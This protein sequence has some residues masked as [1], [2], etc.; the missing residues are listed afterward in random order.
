MTKTTAID[1]FDWG[2]SLPSVELYLQ[3][4]EAERQRLIPNRALTTREA[5][6]MARLENVIEM[7]K[8][9]DDT[10]TMCDAVDH[11]IATWKELF[12]E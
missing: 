4:L 6:I 11:C 10:S 3:D 9:I 5:A 12:S 7:A 8:R 1:E 2:A